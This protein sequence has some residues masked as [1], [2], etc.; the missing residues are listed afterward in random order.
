MNEHAHPTVVAARPMCGGTIEWPFWPNYDHQATI[1]WPLSVQDV[2]FPLPK[3]AVELRLGGKS[4]GQLHDLVGAT[5]L[6][7]LAL[8]LLEALAVAGA[9]TFALA[10]INLMPRHTADVGGNWSTAAR[11]DGYSPRCSCAM[12]TARSRTTAENFLV[13]VLVLVMAAFS[14]E[15]EPPR[16][17]GASR[18]APTRRNR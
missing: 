4:A 10:R 3:P 9:H 14:Q 13:L 16:I 17:P 1:V 18:A 15:L 8:K 6:L 11:N 5:Q 2:A 12:R 7:V